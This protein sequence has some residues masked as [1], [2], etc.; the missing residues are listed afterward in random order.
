[1][2]EEPT[3]MSD[4]ATG[5]RSP[6]EIRRDIERTRTELHDTVDAIERRL[7]PGE[8]FD[9]FWGR[10]R[11]GSGGAGEV[12]KDHPVPIA[13]MGL[14]LGWLAIEKAT[15][16][17][18]S[19]RRREDGPSV[20]WT[21]D[22]AVQW[23]GLSTSRM[24]RVRDAASSLKESASHLGERASDAGHRVGDAASSA[25]H[26]VGETA[27]HARDRVRETAEHTKQRARSGAR[28]VRHEL[29]R[30]RQE[31]PLALGAITFGLGLAA[32][33]LA[34]TTRWEDEHI[35]PASDTVKDTAKEAA[36]EVKEVAREITSEAK[37]VVREAAHSID[38]SARETEGRSIGQ[39][40]GDAVDRAK[41][42]AVHAASEHNID[43]EGLRERGRD[44]AR[45]TREGVRAARDEVRGG[46]Q[47]TTGMAASGRERVEGDI[48]RASG[49]DR[50][51]STSDTTAPSRTERD[52]SSPRTVGDTDWSRAAGMRGGS[53]AGDTSGTTDRNASEQG[54]RFGRTD[55]DDPTRR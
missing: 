34:P 17:D 1:M 44:V 7:T 9:E 50:P 51:G 30:V 15:G 25:G 16:R 29:D 41:E 4:P 21:P 26:R 13:L 48:P 14:G 31:Q 54:D 39:R 27:S 28:R 49:G 47:Q 10:L 11:G 36:G 40:V 23:E 8:L 32:G 19:P 5:D 46:H 38:D 42:T 24:D 22:E 45:H 43:R 6:D 20:E 2:A 53:R 12:V 55:R 33:M 37:E 35:G 18:S 3:R 52:S